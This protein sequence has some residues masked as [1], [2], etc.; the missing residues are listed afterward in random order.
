[1]DPI[2]TALRNIVWQY[3][4]KDPV[5]REQLK[6][7]IEEAGRNLQLTTYSEL[8]NGIIFHLP[9]VMAGAVYQIH[10]LDWSGL[11]RRIIGDFLGHI[12]MESYIEHGFMAS[13][14]VVSGLEY[15]PSKHFF[16]WMASLNVLPNLDEETVLAFWAE[17]VNL[18][19]NWYRSNR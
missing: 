12:T 8:V 6:E 10:T 14:L 3:G 7:R 4:D 11:D 13:V 18:A 15:K 5:A 19:H 9:N 17:H 1:M 16:D 2:E